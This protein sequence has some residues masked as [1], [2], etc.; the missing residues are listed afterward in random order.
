MCT[1]ST[2]L[3]GAQY[4]LPFTTSLLRLRFWNTSLMTQDQPNT[5]SFDSAPTASLGEVLLQQRLSST[6]ATQTSFN[7]PNFNISQFNLN[8]TSVSNIRL[9]C[10]QRPSRDLFPILL[11]INNTSLVASSY[12]HWILYLLFRTTWNALF[13]NRPSQHATPSGSPRVRHEVAS[14]N[15]NLSCF[16][17]SRGSTFTRSFD[18]K[19]AFNPRC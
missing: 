9:S 6:G 17:P 19:G 12:T 13:P 18:L 4:Q 1:P 14:T 10:S 5:R 11:Y 16:V 2:N 15:S 3:D 7:L 8:S